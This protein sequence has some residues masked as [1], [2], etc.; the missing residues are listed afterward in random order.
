MTAR[1]TRLGAA[2]ILAA[3]LAVGVWAAPTA[4]RAVDEARHLRLD[5]SSPAANAVLTSAPPE[6]RLFFSEAPQMSGTTVRLTR[7]TEDLVRTTETRADSTDTK[8]VFIVPSEPLAPGAYTVH[9]RVIARDG[10][11]Q[12]GT[13]GFRIGQ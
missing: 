9:W 10:H 1:F 2:G 7:G 3:I 8:Q 13:F 5:R 12:R 6:I 4:A 11:A